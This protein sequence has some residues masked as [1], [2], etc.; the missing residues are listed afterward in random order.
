MKKFSWGVFIGATAIVSGVTAL[1]LLTVSGFKKFTGQGDHPGY[2]QQWF[3]EKKSADGTIPKWRYAEWSRWDKQQM[4][5]RSGE[6]IIDTVIQ[7]GPANVGGRTR[8]IWLDPKNDKVILAAAISG[9]I[10]RS[11]N[12]G[13]T[14]TPLNDHQESMMASCFTHN[15][16]NSDIVYYGTGESR[17]NSADVNGNGVFK[18][19]DGGRTFTNLP[20]TIG[21]TG[22]DAIWDIEH[23]LIDSNTLFVATHGNGLH[24]S[25]DGGQTWEQVYSGGNLNVNDIL[26]LPDGRLLLSM[27]YNQVYASDSNGKKGT[28]KLVSFPNFP[29]SG[30]YGRIQMANCRKFPNVVYAMFEGYGFNDGPS[31]FY[32]SSN[33]G[34]TW[35]KRTAPTSEAGSGYQTYCVMLGVHATDSNIVIS[36]GVKIA[37][38][39]NGGSTWSNKTTGHSDHHYMIPL[40]SNSNEFLVGNDGGVYKYRYNASAV[41]A[42]LNNGYYTTQ[43]YAGSYGPTGLVSIGGTQDNG[44]HVATGK[45]TSKKFYGA[46]GAYAFIGQ[47]DG[48]VAYF[49]TQNNG[50]RRIDNFNANVAPSFTTGIAPDASNSEGVNFINPYTMSPADQGTLVYRTNSGVH[51]STDNGNNWKKLNTSSRTGIKALAISNSST[52]PVLYYG[53]SAAQIFKMDDLYNAATGSEVSYSSSVPTSVTNDFMSSICIHPKNKYTIFTA[54]S[55]FSNQPRIWKATG[56]DGSSPK[57]TSVSGNL[58]AGLPVN[59]VAVDPAFP[60]KNL[61]A[62]TDFGLYYSTD[63]GKTWTKELRIPNVAVHEVRA[64]ESDR[65]IF[66]ET[67]GRGKWVLGLAVANNTQSVKTKSKISV[68]PNP[69]TDAINIVL[70]AGE[71]ISEWKIYDK[72][73]K[74]I[75]AGNNISNISADNLSLGQYFIT[76]STNRGNYTEKLLIRK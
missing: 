52:T 42:D 20:S 43:F 49:S 29:G 1:S 69:A 37:Q 65:M 56:L 4:N 12:S 2:F 40:Y 75:K 25:T 13:T 16:Y 3:E 10:W 5:R 17:A 72:T 7:L 36:G 23:S 59:M 27:Q 67:H 61:F 74:L 48:S 54:F 18:S 57:W 58:P 9:G 24:R 30:T 38:S 11:E 33:G 45:L 14:W 60:D 19:T 51:M 22:F 50:I 71:M 66:V 39:N 32:K 70:P 47:Q 68:F 6:Q 21:R 35:T 55:N 76:I 31:A 73:G 63:S 26:A 28:F 62:G 8:S 34:R 53:G 64:R 15:P 46:D 41:Q 44:T